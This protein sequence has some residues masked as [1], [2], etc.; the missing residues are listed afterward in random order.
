MHTI[1]MPQPHCLDQDTWYYIWVEVWRIY[2]RPFMANDSNGHFFIFKKR[3][4]LSNFSFIACNK[5]LLWSVK[6]FKRKEEWFW[7]TSNSYSFYHSIFTWITHLRKCSCECR[8]NLFLDVIGLKFQVSN[9]SYIN[10]LF[11]LPTYI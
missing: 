5:T 1:S 4:N 3:A 10:C 9:Y 6:K 8:E 7:N 2:K 11:L